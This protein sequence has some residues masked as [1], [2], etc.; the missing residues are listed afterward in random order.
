MPGRQPAAPADMAPVTAGGAAAWWRD[1]V[2]Y[3]IYLRSFADTDADGV[4]DLHGV[5]DHLDHLEDLGVDLIWVT[6][7]Y[8][9]PLVDLGYDITDHT[10]VDP[11]YGDLAAFDELVDAVHRRGM[12]LLID[13]VPNHTSI[14]HPWFRQGQRER[15]GPYGDYHL[16]ADPA[17]GG[18]P[19]NN[20][21]SY[22]GGPAWT[23]DPVR[24]QYYLHLFLPEQPD[25]NWRNPAVHREFDR[26]LR[27]WLDRGVDGFRIDVAQ[28]LVK[29]RRLRS[30]PQLRPVRPSDD[31]VRQWNAFDHRH[32]VTQP[33]TRD[34]FAGWRSLC[35]SYDAVLVG[36][37]SVASPAGL[38][39]LLPGTGLHLGFWL[40]PARL[41][42]DPPALRQALTAP[43]AA[44]TD[45]ETIAWAASTLDEH[46][47]ATRFGGGDLGR[48]RALALS[49]LLFFLPGVPFLYQGEELGLVDGAVPPEA[50][51]DPV[52][53]DPNGG[54][55]GARTPMPWRPGTA[56]GFSG[57]ARTWLPMG[58][59][60]EADTVARQRGQPSS[61]LERYRALIRMRREMR[62][63]RVGPVEVVDLGT[64]D[65]LAFR[66]QGLVAAA[67]LGPGPAEVP[68]AGRVLYDTHDRLTG[69]PTE[70][71]PLRLAHAQ[72][73]VLASS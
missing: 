61:P 27:F 25:L 62:S 46:R 10:A 3:S 67:N 45:P 29:D 71:S 48:H 59:R 26:I 58:G 55:D 73:V 7:F 23:L 18:G 21:V 16:W 1:A 34:V 47:P 57:T 30:N 63:R 8:P 40:P 20:W 32:D 6:P 14:E 5:H 56:F 41:G 69:T 66:R 44:V 72:A 4:G 19:P 12:R 42:W 54:R 43:L 53:R 15:G 37:T 39:E 50:E 35:A 17:P 9:S 70:P 60:D 36:E 13:L 49:T 2:G 64:D 24:G 28:G 11:L 38:A 31:R 52:A 65:V 68:L 22:F 33:E 51:T